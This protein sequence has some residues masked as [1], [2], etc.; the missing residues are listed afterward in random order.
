MNRITY[1]QE[2]KHKKTIL[3]NHTEKKYKKELALGSTLVT[4]GTMAGL[5]N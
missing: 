2:Y 1:S 5:L 4:A 3:T